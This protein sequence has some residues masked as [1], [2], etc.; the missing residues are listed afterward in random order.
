MS[1]GLFFLACLSL[2]GA[3]VTSWST[4]AE[5]AS[6]T[7]ISTVYFVIGKQYVIHVQSFDGSVF[8]R[9]FERIV[10]PSFAI[11][12]GPMFEIGFGAIFN[13]TGLSCV[14]AVATLIVFL[15]VNGRIRSWLDGVVRRL[16]RGPE[17]PMLL[18]NPP[19]GH[20]DLVVYAVVVFGFPA[21]CASLV[22][23][24]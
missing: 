20:A 13:P 7:F 15:D 4:T 18:E 9:H 6:A 22:L 12:V 3:C 24:I 17:D 14:L 5:A 21:L 19:R 1:G 16:R 2:F 10:L 23:A 11:V 8:Y